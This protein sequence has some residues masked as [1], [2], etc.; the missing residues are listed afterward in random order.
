MFFFFRFFSL[1]YIAMVVYSE[2]S[3]GKL[4]FTSHD[5]AQV[6]TQQEE[7]IV[8]LLVVIRDSLFSWT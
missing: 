4:L 5:I 8:A 7:K 6:Y 2:N 3:S 1:R